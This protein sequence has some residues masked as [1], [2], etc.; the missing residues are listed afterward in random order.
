VKFHVIF[1]SAA[2]FAAIHPISA[3]QPACGPVVFRASVELAASELSLAD[4]VAAPACAEFMHAAGRIR[5]GGAPRAGSPRV[6]TGDELRALL[7]RL[8]KQAGHAA[9]EADSFGIPDRIIVRRAGPDGPP[10]TAPK[11][12]KPERLE[13]SVIREAVPLV[14]PG[15]TVSLS[16]NQDG[17]LLLGRVVC[18]DRGGLGAK[19]RARMPRGSIVNA[20]V[21]GVGQLRAGS[22]EL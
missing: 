4:L 13:F 7:Q 10:R 18:L 12:S 21:A 9:I 16:W 6:F 19:V 14:H 17:I 11:S 3:A 20:V 1:A 8:A 22:S 15:E 2:F 5:L